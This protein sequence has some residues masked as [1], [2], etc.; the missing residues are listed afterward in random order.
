MSQTKLSHLQRWILLSAYEGIVATGI[1]EPTKKKV[2]PWRSYR[3]AKNVH[4]LR[5]DVFQGY[6]KLPLRGRSLY[7]PDPPFLVLDGRENQKKANAARSSLTR[8]L[9]RLR[10]RGLTTDN[11]ITL[12]AE[13]IEVA[14]GLLQRHFRRLHDEVAPAS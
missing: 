14:K 12:T 13:G 7:E 1:E 3:M 8:A 5:A 11:D 10:K 9:R 2:S 4:L 6:F